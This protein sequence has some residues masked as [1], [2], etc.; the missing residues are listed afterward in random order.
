M[1]TLNFKK[2][3]NLSEPKDWDNCA[4]KPGIYIWIESWNDRQ[5]LYYIGKS[6]SSVHQRNLYHFE[7]MVSG[8][9]PVPNRY[10][11]NNSLN[12]LRINN[13][14]EFFQ[15][16]EVFTT[17]LR[18]CYLYRGNINVYYNTEISV[19]ALKDVEAYL[20]KRFI[21]YGNKRKE[22][23]KNNALLIDITFEGIKIPFDVPIPD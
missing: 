13:R 2:L 14:I 10:F 1:E 12:D 8:R 7:H 15:N 16:Y 23:L 4:K 5:Y 21:P 9:E 17:Y 3:G 11:E 6:H 19:S 18:K 20:I 22:P